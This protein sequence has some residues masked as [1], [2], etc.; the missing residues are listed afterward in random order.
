MCRLFGELVKPFPQCHLHSKIW[1]IMPSFWHGDNLN[2]DVPRPFFPMQRVQPVRLV[3]TP[4]ELF[5]NF[6]NCICA[7]HCAIPHFSLN[8]HEPRLGWCRYFSWFFTR[9]VDYARLVVPTEQLFRVWCIAGTFQLMVSLTDSHCL[10][11][12]ENRMSWAAYTSGW[13]LL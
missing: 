5:G 2:W 6:F 3:T 7:I 10:L 13:N 1:V 11:S 9:T 8:F 12:T 4:P